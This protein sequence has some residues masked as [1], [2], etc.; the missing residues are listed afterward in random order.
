MDPFILWD[1]IVRVFPSGFRADT[2]GWRKCAQT[3][4]NLI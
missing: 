2:L 4:L 1:K 3:H